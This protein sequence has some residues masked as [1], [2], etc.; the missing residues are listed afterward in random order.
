MEGSI[1]VDSNE[2]LSLGGV[3]ALVD[4]RC[5]TGE[6]FVLNK[7]ELEKKVTAKRNYSMR[8]NEAKVKHRIIAFSKHLDDYEVVL[9]ILKMLTVIV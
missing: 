8:T 3:E 6:S 5:F 4:I 9:K 7:S 1:S 2:R